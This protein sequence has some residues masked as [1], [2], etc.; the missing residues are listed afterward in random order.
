MTR[1]KAHIQR[2]RLGELLVMTGLLTTGELRYALARQRATGDHLGRILL[3]ER[4]VSRQELYRTLAQQW[5]L[6]AM[7][8][9]T[10]VIIA[11]A[12]FSAKQAR[13][14]SI[15]DIPAQMSLA[16]AANTAFAP[17]SH[18][19]DLFGA[20]ERRSG[21]L[22]AFTKW[23]SMFKR[24]EASMQTST[25][26][27]V[28]NEWQSGIEAYAGLPLEQ[29]AARVNDFVNRTRYVS[30]MANWGV[31]DHWATPIEFFQRGGDCEDFAIAKYASLRA[32]GVPE[33]RLRIAVVQDLE[34]NIPH[35][36]LIVYTD[37]GAM[38]LDNQI[39]EARY[40]HQVNRYKPIFS[41][42]RY[43]W[44]LHN[45]PSHTVMAA[46]PAGNN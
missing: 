7:A 37:N 12:A 2:N 19:P 30:D 39:R 26:Q 18:Y 25:G 29:M 32:L 41:I 8:A 27:Q 38:M 17:I 3:H 28:I 9:A 42:N 6:R 36:I 21:N 33:E 24:F 4:M 34:K 40:T 10:T 44:W 15:R 16:A 1:F 5:T 45:A 14:S 13:A 23:T 31:S 20:D 22:S 35:A 43:A 46:A 11:C